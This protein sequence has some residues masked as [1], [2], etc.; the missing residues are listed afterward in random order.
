MMRRCALERQWTTNSWGEDRADAPLP[1]NGTCLQRRG[2][3]AGGRGG[4]GG[5]GAAG[6]NPRRGTGSREYEHDSRSK[7][8]QRLVPR[9]RI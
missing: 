6:R 7:F 3:E 2:A 8:V 9:I 5:G 1:V 4:G